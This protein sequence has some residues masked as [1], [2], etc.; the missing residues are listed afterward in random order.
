MGFAIMRIEKHKSAVSIRKFYRHALRILD[1]KNSDKEKSAKNKYDVR[2]S[3]EDFIR[4]ALSLKRRK[5]AVIGLELLMTYSLNDSE[6]KLLYSEK[7]RAGTFF[8]EWESRAKQ[9]LEDTF[10]VENVALVALHMDETTPHLSAIVLPICNGRL[11]AKFW[12]NGKQALR[13]LQDSYHKAVSNVGGVELQRGIKGSKARHVRIQEF[14]Q[15]LND[16]VVGA[17]VLKSGN[18]DEVERVIKKLLDKATYVDILQKKLDEREK[19]INI[20]QS[21]LHDKNKKD[22]NKK[23][24]KEVESEEVGCSYGYG[25]SSMGMGM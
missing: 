9:W 5:D 20:L 15:N 19:Q 8:R 24:K 10:G 7:E 23:D 17:S 16:N 18:I 25:Y 3:E 21:L 22:K 12:T 14:Y 6:R 4:K 11:N 13:N 2:I 1:V